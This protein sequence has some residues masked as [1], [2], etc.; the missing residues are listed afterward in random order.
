MKE[1]DDKYQVFDIIRKKY[2]I[3]TPEEWVR[4]HVVHYLL[5]Y[6]NYPKGLIKLE[7]GLKFHKLLKRTDI[8]VHDHEGTPYLL[9]ECKA[10][11]IK[12]NQKVIE[13]A[14]IYN[15]KVSARFILLTNGMS[16]YCLVQEDGSDKFTMYGDI[17][18]P[19]SK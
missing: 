13:Q 4:Q 17:P 2:V 9:V 12:I 10:P 8:L 16:H 6:H 1:I 3:L 7:G 18:S 19:P 5:Q 11:S 15:Q 14:S